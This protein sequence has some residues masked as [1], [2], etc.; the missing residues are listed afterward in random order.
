VSVAATTRVRWKHL[1]NK[2]VVTMMI[3]VVSTE[4]MKGSGGEGK[5]AVVKREKR[6]RCV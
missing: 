3:Y 2:R 4:A 6:K 1:K 5:R